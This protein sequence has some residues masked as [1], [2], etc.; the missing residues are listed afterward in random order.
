MVSPK[1]RNRIAAAI[2]PALALCGCASGDADLRSDASKLYEFDAPRPLMDVYAS[3]IDM[4]IT[5]KVGPI[6]SMFDLRIDPTMDRD[7][8]T[9][10][11]ALVA[12]GY[13]NPQTWGR[14]DMEPR[15][16]LTHVRIF[17]ERKSALANLGRDVERWA[18]AGKG[19]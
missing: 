17:G 16:S 14:I 6:S 8:H 9:A 2:F 10:S 15:G 4:L 5:C 12:T 19:C 7:K 1:L 3:E 13:F 11:I 18:N